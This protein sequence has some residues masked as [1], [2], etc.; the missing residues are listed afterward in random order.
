MNI[1]KIVVPSLIVLFTIACASSAFAQSRGA[2][3]RAEAQP[4]TQQQLQT[5]VLERRLEVRE[6]VFSTDEELP[7]Q[8]HLVVQFI[9][10]ADGSV[11]DVS[12][13]ESNAGV[14]AVDSCVIGVVETVQFPSTNT[15][16]DFA[17]R[18]PFI[19]ITDA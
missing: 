7:R 5:A 16:R 9:I 1:S 4:L 6:C 17:V 2:S 13:H 10:G 18:Y 19:F 12:M 3:H 8:L 14:D 11:R 15:G